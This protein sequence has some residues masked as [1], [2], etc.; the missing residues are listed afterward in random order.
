MAKDVTPYYLNEPDNNNKISFW[1]LIQDYSLYLCQGFKD[2]KIIEIELC[3]L[4]FLL[5]FVLK[6]I[7][8]KFI[9]KK[10]YWTSYL[11]DA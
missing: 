10:I 5:S 8:K 3:S 11:T 6:C 9:E 7:F 1:K 2:F 4:L